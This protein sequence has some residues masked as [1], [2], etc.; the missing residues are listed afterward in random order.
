MNART[1]EDVARLFPRNAKSPNL[2]VEY[3]PPT[4]RIPPARNS[5]VTPA[6]LALQRRGVVTT[7][8]VDLPNCCFPSISRGW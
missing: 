4:G 7:A 2:K 5:L 6:Y 8:C 3:V 1:R